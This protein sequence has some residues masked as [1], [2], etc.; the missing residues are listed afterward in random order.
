M[1]S[2]AVNNKKLTSSICFLADP[3]ITDI[4]IGIPNS[5][6]HIYLTF[7]NK[8]SNNFAWQWQSTFCEIDAISKVP[9][10]GNLNLNPEY[11]WTNTGTMEDFDFK[12]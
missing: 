3:L 9:R 7:K 8:L 1:N 5:D 10:F 12:F 2:L 11:S 4:Q 6:F